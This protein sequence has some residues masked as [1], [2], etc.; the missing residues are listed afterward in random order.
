MEF[1]SN[2]KLISVIIPLYNKEK[3]VSNSVQSVLN[4]T[5][6]N[7]ELII[8]DDG[9]TDNSFNIVDRI[10]DSRIRLYQKSNGGV[11]SARNFGITHAK[12]NLISFLDADDFWEPTFLIEML[13]L[14]KDFQECGIYCFA[15]DQV[16]N[17][18][19]LQTDFFVPKNYRG[20]IEDYFCQAK[21]NV[22]FSS[23]SVLIDISI[24]KFNSY[25]D[26]RI[27]IGEDLFLWLRIALKTK[28]CFYNK[29][30][31]FYIISAENR[32]MTKKTDFTKSYLNYIHEIEDFNN[33]TFKSFINYQCIHELFFLFRRYNITNSQFESYLSILDFTQQSLKY[34]LF[35]L[36]PNKLK[37]IILKVI[38]D[39]LPSLR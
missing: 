3:S 34:R 4:Q 5:Y 38:P 1:E 16:Y 24:I 11:S 33:L 31:A 36:F 14:K 20:I 30:L 8:V 19:V 28:V 7:F 25:F 39:V 13:E 29:V 6:N 12:S 18:V 26:E 32:A 22:L 2:N 37:A 9:S 21:K 15:Y 27:T 17:S 10:K 23:S 35:S